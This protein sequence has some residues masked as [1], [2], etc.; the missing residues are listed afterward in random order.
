MVQ[1]SVWAVVL[2][3]P[4]LNLLHSNDFLIMPLTE[5]GL[6]LFRAVAL[7]NCVDHFLRA[8]IIHGIGV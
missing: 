7:R 4:C 6:S 8:F 2:F 1:V 3:W 5:F